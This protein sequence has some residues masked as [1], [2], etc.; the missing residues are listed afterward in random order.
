MS[1]FD[2]MYNKYSNVFSIELYMMVIITRVEYKSA[3]E[4]D[5]TDLFTHLTNYSI[6]K[7]SKN[8]K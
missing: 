3:K 2:A 7:M 5:L 4:S 8:Y 6:N 1:P